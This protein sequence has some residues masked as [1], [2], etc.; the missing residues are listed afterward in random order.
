MC[1]SIP[2]VIQRADSSL[3]SSSEQAH[4][5]ANPEQ[6]SLQAMFSVLVYSADSFL[7]HFMQDMNQGVHLF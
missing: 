5:Q 4:N 1:N 3:H 2:L 6:S 7:G